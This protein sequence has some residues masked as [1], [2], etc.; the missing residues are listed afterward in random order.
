MSAETTIPML[1]CFGIS[2]ACFWMWFK[3]TVPKENQ[4][5]NISAER[6]PPEFTL[7]K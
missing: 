3:I 2:L 6:R 4:R 7:T 5:K 1:A